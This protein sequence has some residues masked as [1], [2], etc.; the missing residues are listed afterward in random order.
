MSEAFAVWAS[1]HFSN[2]NSDQGIGKLFFESQ[3]GEV[4]GHGGLVGGAMSSSRSSVS[5]IVS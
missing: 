4:K 3:F 5:S 1:L 2:V